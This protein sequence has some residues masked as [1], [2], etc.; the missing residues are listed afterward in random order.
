LHSGEETLAYLGVPLKKK[1]FY[2]EI[3]SL[4]YCG[5]NVKEKCDIFRK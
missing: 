1:R 4:Y 2:S 3:E 5:E